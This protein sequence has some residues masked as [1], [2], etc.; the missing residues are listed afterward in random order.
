[1]IRRETD[2]GTC[3]AGQDARLTLN[4]TDVIKHQTTLKSDSYVLISKEMKATDVEARLRA[5]EDSSSAAGNAARRVN[6]P[7]FGAR[8]GLTMLTV[9]LGICSFFLFK[10]K[11]KRQ[12]SGCHGST[13]AKTALRE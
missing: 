4:Y 12:L 7:A 8:T 3:E 1:M 10:A 6:A 5:A 13:D 2:P 11:L 9:G